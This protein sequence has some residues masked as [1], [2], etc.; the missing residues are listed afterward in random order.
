VAGFGR[1]LLQRLAQER[2]V[3]VRARGRDGSPVDLPVWI[4]VVDD[5]P[6]V[7]S[8]RAERGAWYRR[9]R[10]A[11]RMTLVVG[12]QVLPVLVRPV[13]DDEVNRRV[14]EAFIA[15]YGNRGPGRTMVSEAVA[16]TT[17]RLAPA[18]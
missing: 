6:Y 9:A 18:G 11:G 4:V 3:Q 16:A 1:G 2:E 7:R 15:K 13:G 12:G 5:E 14:S 10:A 8:Y 17:L